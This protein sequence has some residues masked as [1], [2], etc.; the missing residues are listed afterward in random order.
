MIIDI[1]GITKAY[2]QGA[3]V[4]PVLANL[5]FSV[6][7]SKSIAIIGKS[8]SGKSTFLSLGAGLDKP[9]TGSIF[10]HG[11]DITT[12]SESELAVFRAKHI[13]IIFQQFHL[14]QNLTA[15][16]NV[17]LPLEILGIKDAV[18]KA[19][20]SLL[21]VGLTEREGHF[22]NELSGGEKQRVAIARAI[23]TKP[24]VIFAD[25]PSG[26][27]DDQ[28]GKEVMELLFNLVQDSATTLVLVTHDSELAKQCDEVYLLADQ[29][30]KKQ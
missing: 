13:G 23:V 1:Q 14:M 4:V 12:L 21:Q 11:E 25:E 19:H 5:N 8:G 17:L 15:F 29:G 2:N 9:S 18:E 22:P 28:T 10:V 6:K 30:L 3:R 24:S 7:E 27:L 20:H 26:N 16:E